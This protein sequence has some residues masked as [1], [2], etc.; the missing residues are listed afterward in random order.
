MATNRKYRRRPHRFPLDHWQQ[1]SLWLGEDPNHHAFE[2]E[3]ERCAAWIKHRDYFMATCYD[4]PGGRCAAW[5]DYES[6]IRRPKDENY[7]AAALWEVDGLLDDEERSALEKMWR[8]YFDQAQVPE[9]TYHTGHG[10]LEGAKARAAYYR[11]SGIPR[12]LVKQWRAERRRSARTIREL[13]KE[14]APA[15]E[16]AAEGQSRR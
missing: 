4:H 12:T 9:F 14:A 7:C 1:T 8:E 5:W 11:W 10:R 16:D 3:A 6:P 13:E 2:S 15:H